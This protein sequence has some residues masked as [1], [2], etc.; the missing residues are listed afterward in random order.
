MVSSQDVQVLIDLANELNQAA[1]ELSQLQDKMSA[2]DPDNDVVS[3]LIGT[4]VQQAF[5]LQ[6]SAVSA[7]LAIQGNALTSVG[8]ATGYLKRQAAFISDVNTAISIVGGLT[9][10]AASIIAGDANGSLS[11]ASTLIGLIGATNAATP[12]ASKATPQAI[13]AGP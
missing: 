8:V 11:A 10:L 7:A 9:A 4:L 5:T 13:A 2:N 6:N 12:P 1:T 3:H